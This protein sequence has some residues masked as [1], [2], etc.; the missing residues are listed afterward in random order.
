MD[1]Y[2]V[3]VSAPVRQAE[4]QNPTRLAS[5]KTVYV[6]NDDSKRVSNRET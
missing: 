2:E 4:F 3:K 6:N 1:P 5:G